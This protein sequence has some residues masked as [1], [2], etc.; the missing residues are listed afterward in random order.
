MCRFPCQPPRDGGI[1]V[2]VWLAHPARRLC[3]CVVY[4]CFLHCSHSRGGD[5]GVA[6]RKQRTSL[7]SDSYIVCSV[8]PTRSESPMPRKKSRS[9]SP[10]VLLMTL[11]AE[12][13][14]STAWRTAFRDEWF[15]LADNRSDVG[16]IEE[17]A[18]ELY[19]THW[20]RHPTE[21]AHEEW[22]ESRAES[23]S[24]NQF[25]SSLTKRDFRFRFAVWR[26]LVV[27][28]AS[29]LLTTLRSSF[30]ERAT[31]R[32]RLGVFNPH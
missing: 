29:A 25:P 11:P 4:A 1:V 32:K 10:G 24:R 20:R 28:A 14:T 18:I 17:W 23:Y 19:P 7:P 13:P 27:T 21:V 22:H 8:A 2:C 31:K 16:D 15:R 30:A 3:S 12:F 6:C 5:N 26:S 9:T